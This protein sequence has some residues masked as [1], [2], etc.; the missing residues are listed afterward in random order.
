LRAEI[1]VWRRIDELA[2][3]RVPGE[4]DKQAFHSI[5]QALREYH[6]LVDSGANATHI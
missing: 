1:E 3:P 5:G 2:A 4:I 6:E